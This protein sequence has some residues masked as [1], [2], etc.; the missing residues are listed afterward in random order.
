M[1]AAGPAIDTASGNERAGDG[2]SATQEDTAYLETRSN[3]ARTPERAL[4]GILSIADAA[5]ACRESLTEC[6]AIESLREEWAEDRLADFKL[7]DAG[8]GASSNKKASLEERLILKPHVRNVVLDL[9]IVLK[10]TFDQCRELGTRHS[11]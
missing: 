4:G 3:A 7:W 5:A 9:L 1:E 10:S 8:V 2:N 11:W 6:L